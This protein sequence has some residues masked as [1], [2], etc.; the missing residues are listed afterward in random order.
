MFLVD[1]PRLPATA[2]NAPHESLR[3]REPGKRTLHT[4]LQVHLNGNTQWVQSTHKKE[5]LVAWEKVLKRT[6]RLWKI[7]KLQRRH[8][9]NLKPLKH[10]PTPCLKPQKLLRCE[11]GRP[12]T[13]SRIFLMRLSL[14]PHRRQTNDNAGPSILLTFRHGSRTPGNPTWICKYIYIYIYTYIHIYIYI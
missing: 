7:D 13:G 8:A 10:P 6:V 4:G 1:D 12:K 14:A 3:N 5:K 2:E 11:A 9:G